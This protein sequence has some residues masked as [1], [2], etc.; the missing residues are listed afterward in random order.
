MVGPVTLTPER[1]AAL[2]AVQGAAATT[3]TGPAAARAVAE[4][5]LA[6]LD[7]LEA[8][9]KSRAKKVPDDPGGWVASV[10]RGHV[11]AL[12]EDCS[13]TGTV[14]PRSARVRVGATR[15]TVNDD[16]NELRVQ[17]VV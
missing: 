8:A 14:N 3:D 12:T 13:F 10:A 1:R 4:K 15:W 5:A 7:G 16:E 6:A 9:S 11:S 17:V 2:D